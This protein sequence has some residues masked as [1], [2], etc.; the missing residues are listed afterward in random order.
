MLNCMANN[1]A[2]KRKDEASFSGSQESFT[3]N[4]RKVQKCASFDSSFNSNMD[5][6]ETMNSEASFSTIPAFKFTI[7]KHV[8]ANYQNPV[9]LK[10]EII[11]A[12]PVINFK[13]IKFISIKNNLV[14][15]ATDDKNTHEQLTNS[16][17]PDS[18]TNGITRTDNVIKPLEIVIKGVHQEIDLSDN[19]IKQ[20]LADQGIASFQRIKKRTDG[21]NSSIVKATVK[22]RLTY[23]RVISDKVKI[24][25]VRHRIKEP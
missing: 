10:R 13:S 18:F 12:K 24:S 25:S 22:D 2:R 9:A 6:D 11:R 19:D 21:S 4:Q 14:I 3:Q 5:E 7:S 23:D 8:A 15:I 1:Q 20:E 16:W 17:P